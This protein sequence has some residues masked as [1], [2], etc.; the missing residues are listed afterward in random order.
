[1]PPGRAGD[2]DISSRV[3][4]PAFVAGARLK[5]V[6]LFANGAMTDEIG[7]PLCNCR[8]DWAAIGADEIDVPDLHRP[9]PQLADFFK[10]FEASTTTN[11][12]PQRALRSRAFGRRRM[13]CL[14]LQLARQI[15][16][17]SACKG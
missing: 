14:Q 11:A 17:K 12:P 4:G 9:I 8:F 5:G 15:S 6:Q 7:R 10:G 13:E 1:M 16:T 3:G 2:W